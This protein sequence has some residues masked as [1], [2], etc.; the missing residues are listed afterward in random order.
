[1]GT[2]VSLVSACADR[3]VW[4]HYDLPAA[5]AMASFENTDFCNAEKARHD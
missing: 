2:L 4:P 3:V 1:V 5:E